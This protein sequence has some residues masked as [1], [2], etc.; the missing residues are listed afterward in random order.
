MVLQNVPT[1]IYICTYIIHLYTKLFKIILLTLTEK[2][3]IDIY[4]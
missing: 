1:Y 3:N 4:F 2:D